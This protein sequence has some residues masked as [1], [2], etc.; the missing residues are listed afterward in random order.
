MMTIHVAA[1]A[2]MTAGL[3]VLTTVP[4]AAESSGGFPAAT[5]VSGA[6]GGTFKKPYTYKPDF[7]GMSKACRPPYT[8]PGGVKRQ[9]YYKGS[10]MGQ[11]DRNGTVLRVTFPRTDQARQRMAATKQWA[12]SCTNCNYYGGETWQRP[13]SAPKVGTTSTAVREYECGYEGGTACSYATTVITRARNVMIVATY[14]L[15]GAPL[16]D[17]PSVVVSPSKTANLARAAIRALP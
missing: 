14:R 2:A 4:A 15:S 10:R 3:T 11:W 12:Q 6:L 5:D 8:E 9:A 13:L 7:A 16:R 1:A 17:D